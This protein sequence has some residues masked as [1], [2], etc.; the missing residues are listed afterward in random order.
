MTK[1]L[2]TKIFKTTLPLL[3]L[4]DIVVFPFMAIPL[5]VGREHS[6]NA[7]KEAMR[8]DQFI[9][10]S[11]Q[12]SFKVDS[13]APNDIYHIGTVSRVSQLVKLPDGSLKILAEGIRR[14]RVKRFLDEK[15]FLRSR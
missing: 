10:L 1:N 4:R 6:I 3:P 7:L 5:L 11:T 15:A 9:V 2:K 8:E 12:K 14:V 13:P